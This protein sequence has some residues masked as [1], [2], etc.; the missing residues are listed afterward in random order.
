MHA[1]EAVR[2]RK[3]E[4]RGYPEFPEERGIE[5]AQVLAIAPVEERGNRVLRIARRNGFRHVAERLGHVEEQLRAVLERRCAEAYER[6]HRG[7]DVS[8]ARVTGRVV[9][10]VIEFPVPR[11]LGVKARATVGDGYVERNRAAF[12]RYV[13]FRPY[14]IVAG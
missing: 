7:D 8:D 14:R 9:E 3:D 4:H 11:H 13:E 2:R 10:V 6:L 5:D 1:H 12:E